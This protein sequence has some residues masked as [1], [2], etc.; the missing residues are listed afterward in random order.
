[1]SLLLSELLN[2]FHVQVVLD[3]KEWTQM[4]KERWGGF[5]FRHWWSFSTG[6]ASTSCLIDL[7]H[8]GIL[9]PPCLKCQLLL[10]AYK[11]QSHRGVSPFAETTYIEKVWKG[12]LDQL[13]CRG[14]ALGLLPPLQLYDAPREIVKWS[15]S[16]M[17]C[18]KFV[19]NTTL[20]RSTWE[21]FADVQ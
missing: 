19:K 9:W 2:A 17:R 4:E 16:S 20:N 21:I 10:P 8:W 14:Q 15:L 5:K 1:M 13:Y 7:C 6:W 11:A 3:K 18:L 12:G